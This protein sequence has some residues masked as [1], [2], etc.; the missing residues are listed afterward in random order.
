MRVQFNIVP[1]DKQTFSSSDIVGGAFLSLQHPCCTIAIKIGIAWFKIFEC[2]TLVDPD[3]GEA[4]SNINER[5]ASRPST[6][7]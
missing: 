4:V 5:A 2:L 1:A 6:L 3:H 7:C